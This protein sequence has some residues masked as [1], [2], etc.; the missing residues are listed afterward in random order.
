MKDTLPGHPYTVEC[1][2][3]N[4]NTHSQSESDWMCYYRNKDQRIYFDS[5][6]QITPV[7]V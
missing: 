6:G 7:E 5:S 1:G 2:I 3:V 4:F